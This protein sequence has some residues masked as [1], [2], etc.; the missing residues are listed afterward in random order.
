MNITFQQYLQEQSKHDY[1]RAIELIESNSLHEGVFDKL[2]S[3]I[4]SKIEFIKSLAKSAKQDVKS[5]IPLLKNKQIFQFFA[6]IKF[7]LSKLFSILKKGY[8]M[9]S[10]LEGIITTYIAD[11]KVVKWTQNELSKLDK[12]LS[13]HPV[14]KRFGGLVVAG[15]LVY[16]WLNMS[17][18]PIDI[19]WSLSF[20]DII[21]AL[22]GNFSISDLFAGP[23]GIKMLS[24]LVIGMMTGGV[25][26]YPGSQAS[27]IVAG[28][29][30]SLW[31]TVI[32]D[33]S[34]KIPRPKLIK[35]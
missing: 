20:E 32:K 29:L 25:W 11:S 14:I 34:V 10:K 17:Y 26:Y 33:K 19:E 5:I 16:I 15:L 22:A 8:K 35:V 1:F 21:K 27:Q 3:G 9:Y 7:S 30:Y 4:K 23:S 24:Y 2:T 31:K 13:D 6:K 28:V 18:D 12:F